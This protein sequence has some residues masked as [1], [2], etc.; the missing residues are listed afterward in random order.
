M[1]YQLNSETKICELKIANCKII[2]SLNETVCSGC[3]KGYAW[4]SVT[5]KCVE[6]PNCLETDE[7]E[8]KCTKCKYDY[9]R[10]IFK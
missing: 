5:S 7:T 4:N 2:S 3:E 1:N 8:A 6:Y 9:Y 10:P